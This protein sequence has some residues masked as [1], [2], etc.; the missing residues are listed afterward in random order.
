MIVAHNYLDFSVI[1][2]EKYVKKKHRAHF[3]FC[4]MDSHLQIWYD[5]IIKT[6]IS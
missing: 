6:D 3:N 1:G 2:E 4:P 5:F